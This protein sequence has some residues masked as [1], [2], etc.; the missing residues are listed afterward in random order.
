MLR[1]LSVAFAVA[2]VACL[3]VAVAGMVT[4]RQS[5]R[6]GYVV[7]VLALV[8]FAAAVALNVAAH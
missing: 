4:G 1:A 3:G 5:A 8:C 2:A 6:T 7:R